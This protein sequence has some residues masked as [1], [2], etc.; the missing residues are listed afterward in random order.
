MDVTEG[1]RRLSGRVADRYGWL[2]HPFARSPQKTSVLDIARH[3]AR[4]DKG[5][6]LERN[7]CPRGGGTTSQLTIEPETAIRG[8]G[9]LPPPTE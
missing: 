3:C 4:W 8:K 6:S 1:F 5:V 9:P 7:S 2:P